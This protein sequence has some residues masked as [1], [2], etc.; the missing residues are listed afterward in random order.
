MLPVLAAPLVGLAGEAAAPLVGTVGQAI[1]SAVDPAAIAYRQQ[2]KK[3]VK[4]LREGK[5]GLSEAEKRTMLAGTQRALQAQTSAAEASLRRSAAAMG[6]FGRSGA[7]QAAL[8]QMGAAQREE[9]TRAASGIEALSQQ[10]A[11]QRFADIMGR[12]AAKRRE[13]RGMGEAAALGAVGMA[14]EAAA[15]YPGLKAAYTEQQLKYAEE[16]AKKRALA[17]QAQTAPAGQ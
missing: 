16:E 14:Q 12:L 4:A 8:G 10:K 7:Q 2:M 3:D 13:A 11:E 1:A 6:G 5:L 9:L 17:S 15:A